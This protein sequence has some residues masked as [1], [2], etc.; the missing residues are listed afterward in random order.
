[1]E[2]NVVPV[3]YIKVRCQTF[4]IRSSLCAHFLNCGNKQPKTVYIFATLELHSDIL[5]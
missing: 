3:L 1:M 2:L 5:K 4:F